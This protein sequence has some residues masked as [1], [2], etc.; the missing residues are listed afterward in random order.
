MGR[1]SIATFDSAAFLFEIGLDVACGYET[2]RQTPDKELFPHVFLR[3]LL[4]I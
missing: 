2:R 1:K 3:E 4:F